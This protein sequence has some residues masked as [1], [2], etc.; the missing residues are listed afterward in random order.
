MGKTL[1]ELERNDLQEG[2]FSEKQVRTARG[3]L[4]VFVSNL[5]PTFRR[6]LLGND[7]T[8]WEAIDYDELN[9]DERGQFDEVLR[10]Y[11]RLLK[12]VLKEWERHGARRQALVSADY[13]S[14]YFGLMWSEVKAQTRGGAP[15][16]S[17]EQRVDVRRYEEFTRISGRLVNGFDLKKRLQNRRGFDSEPSELE[18]KRAHL[19]PSEIAV[20]T[21]AR[22]LRLA[23]LFLLQESLSLNTHI[24]LNTLSS[25]VKRGERYLREARARTRSDRV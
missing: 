16:K 17:I 19:E 12:S 18:I 6:L 4:A 20:I 7:L 3:R 1:E 15:R 5:T 14:I 23:A 22:T 9:D 24:S 13:A 2:S 10:E 8:G 25:S 21:K 11:H